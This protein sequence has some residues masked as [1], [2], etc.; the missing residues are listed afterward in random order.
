M[1]TNR[2]ITNITLLGASGYTG[3]LISFL[4]KEHGILFS[5]AGRNSE[6][7][8]DLK[9]EL[10]LDTPF[11]LCDITKREDLE[12]L[13]QKTDVLINCVGPYNL[14][15]QTLI[16]EVVKHPVIYLDLTGEQS[17][18]KNSI[19]NLHQKASEN[20]A[21][22]IHSCS[23]ESCLAD[24]MA[25]LLVDQKQSYKSISSFYHFS[26]TRPSPGTRFTM[27]VSRHF[28]TYVLENHQL[29]EEPPIQRQFPVKWTNPEVDIAALMP[30]PEVLF[31]H[32]KYTVKNAGSYLLT[33]Q[34][35]FN[36]TQGIE[37]KSLAEIIEKKEQR[38]PST[39]KEE[40]RKKQQFSLIVHTEAED[41]KQQ[42]IELN[43]KDMYQTTAHIILYF[44]QSFIQSVPT[45]NGVF[46]PSE[47]LESPALLN[48]ICKRCHLELKESNQLKISK[49]QQ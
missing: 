40:E 48:T 17:F 19:E 33:A 32:K 22:L 44:I 41:G 11:I 8:K 23:F 1:Q 26:K 39:L 43:G 30:Y 36:M 3:K 27:Q 10:N 34:A 37:R 15:G 21:L 12:L 13:L 5:L 29:K 2:S 24:M 6:K 14:Y 45:Q 20:K 7:L 16:E 25:D 42:Q 35:E 46:T 38:K 47:I 31:Y 28:P 49:E 18:V 4:L 9:T